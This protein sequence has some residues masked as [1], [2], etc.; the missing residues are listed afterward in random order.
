MLSRAVELIDADAALRALAPEWEALWRRAPDAT[1]FQSPAWL[2]AWW[3]RFGTGAPR[4]ST[5]RAGDGRLLGLLA[6]YLLDERD[7][8]KLLPIGAGV[9]DYLD[10]LLDADASPDTAGWLLEAA[11]RRARA[12]GVSICDLTDLPP[13]SPLRDAP[14]S[15]GWRGACVPTD[16]CPVLRLSATGL[17]ASVPA[18][19]RRDLRQARH[20]AMRIGGWASEIATAETAQE[21]LR[22]LARL[23]AARWDGG[24]V[25]D[26]RV[27]AFH[28]DAA[29]ALLACGALRLQALRFGCDIAAV[30]YALLAGSDRVLFYLSGFDAAYARASPGTLL[31][32]EMIEAAIAEGRRELHFLRG[33]EAY[34]YAWGGVDRFNATR[35]LRPA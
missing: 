22:A 4:V 35:R 15:A 9:S 8:R 26:E 1:P 18:G 12:D 24:G 29:P 34:K 33:A 10:A 16:P 14:P 21:L 28:R 20:R 7:E 19:K 5:L 6:L 23:H 25:L 32:G 3:R 27:M 17:A 30:Y 13:G 31:L 11:L 2:L